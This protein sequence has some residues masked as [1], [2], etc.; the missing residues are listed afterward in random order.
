MIGQV[1]R[2]RLIMRAVVPELV[3]AM[4]AARSASTEAR[5]A[6]AVMA[7]VMRTVVGASCEPGQ[8]LLAEPG[9]PAAV[10]EV[11]LGSRG[12][13]GHRVHHGDG[14]DADG[15]LGREH[16]RAGAVEHR[17][18]DVGHLGAGGRRAR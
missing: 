4:I 10:V 3:Q 2:K 7:E 6:A 13:P 8:L 17:V 9:A 16:H 5:Q 1:G 12:D 14:V 15:R 11:A 18:G